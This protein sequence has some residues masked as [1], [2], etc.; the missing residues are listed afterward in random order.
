MV[1]EGSITT[2][3]T[4]SKR[5]KSRECKVLGMPVGLLAKITQSWKKITQT[6]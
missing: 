4:G 5:K 6:L 1:E 2:T 3:I